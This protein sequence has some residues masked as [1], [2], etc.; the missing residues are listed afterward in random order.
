M[1]IIITFFFT[2]S[3]IVNCFFLILNLE[4]F[5]EKAIVKSKQNSMIW[6]KNSG[7]TT[8]LPYY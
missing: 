7:Q 8:L 1:T 2:F 4:R 5:S 3:K 6:Q